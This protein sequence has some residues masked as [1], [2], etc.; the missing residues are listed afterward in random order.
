MN[1]V[2]VDK[3]AELSGYTRKAVEAKIDTG[4]WIEGVQYCRAPD[5]RIVINIEKVEAW[6]RGE[7]TLPVATSQAKRR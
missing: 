6:Q 5:R 7:L 1:Q 3:F 2:L 4:V